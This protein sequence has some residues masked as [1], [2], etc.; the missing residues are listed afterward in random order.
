MDDTTNESLTIASIADMLE[1]VEDVLGAYR[2]LMAIDAEHELVEPDSYE[3]GRHHGTLF[4]L[5]MMHAW[6]LAHA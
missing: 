6:M 2:D 4:T 5:E 1:F 3:E